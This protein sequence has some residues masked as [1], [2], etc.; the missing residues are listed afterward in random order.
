MCHA[1]IKHLDTLEANHRPPDSLKTLGPLNCIT[2]AVRLLQRDKPNRLDPDTRAPVQATEIQ[3]LAR[4]F[5]PSHVPVG[6]TAAEEPAPGPSVNQ[7]KLLPVPGYS[8]TSPR[9]RK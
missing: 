1:T 3:T 8:T 9:I 2:A 4:N 5:D 7:H 6:E